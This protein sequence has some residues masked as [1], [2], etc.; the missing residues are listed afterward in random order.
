MLMTAIMLHFDGGTMYRYR[1][2]SLPS[3][4]SCGVWARQQ[5]TP[6][7]TEQ[8]LEFTVL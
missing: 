3:S 1:R 8:A 4:L 6:N 5:K 2:P 7:L